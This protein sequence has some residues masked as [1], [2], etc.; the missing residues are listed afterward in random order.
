MESIWN[1]FYPGKYANPM[2]DTDETLYMRIKKISKRYPSRIALEFGAKKYTYSAFFNKIVETANCWRKL[3]VGKGDKVLLLMGHNPMNLISLFALDKLGASAALAVP[4]LST[5]YFVEY[6]NSV[7]ASYCVM[8]GNQYWNYSSVL[9]NTKIRTVVIGKYRSMISG[10]DR[11]SFYF[12]T[13]AEYDKPKPQ[14]CPEGIRRLTWQEV[15]EL[16]D[17]ES[18]QHL[19]G[20]DRDNEQTTLYLFPSEGERDKK[21][22]ADLLWNGVYF[23]DQEALEKLFN[24]Y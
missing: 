22:L 24:I 8:S 11:F 4:N 17:V 12:D 20:Y 1:V 3:G 5:E 23:N 15:T 19:A 18:D 7:G 16:P 2:T 10:I 9:K 14:N 21:V 6:A 13:L